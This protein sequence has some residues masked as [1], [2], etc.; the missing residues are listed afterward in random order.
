MSTKKRSKRSRFPRV[1]LRHPREQTKLD[2]VQSRLAKDTLYQKL[3][4]AREEATTR[5]LADV[6]EHINAS[7]MYLRLW[8]V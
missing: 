4:S 2:I 6:I 3:L 5:R 8:Y 1:L 7:L